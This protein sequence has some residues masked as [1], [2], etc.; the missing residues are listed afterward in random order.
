[1]LVTGFNGLKKTNTTQNTTAYI[2]HD[3]VE[4][5]MDL[6][7]ELLGMNPVSTVLFLWDCGKIMPKA[8]VTVFLL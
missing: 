4:R 5:I 3:I 2:S 1:M 8:R 6:R 7:E